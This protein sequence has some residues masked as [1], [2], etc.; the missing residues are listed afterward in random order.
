MDA[1]LT[2]QEKAVAAVV[3]V[4]SGGCLLGRNVSPPLLLLAGLSIS[5]RK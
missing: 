4:R 2:G 3:L 5:V 1:E